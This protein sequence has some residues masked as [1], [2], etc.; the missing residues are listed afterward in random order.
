M[1]K[2]RSV[3]ATPDGTSTAVLLGSRGQHDDLASSETP[4]VLEAVELTAGYGD[5]AAIRDVSLTVRRGEIVALFGANGAGKTTTLM[6]MVG[7]L[8]R[9]GG[10]VRWRDAGTSEPLYKL[11]RRGLSFVPEEQSIISGLSVRDNLRIGRGTVKKALEFFPELEP[12]LERNAG[13][14]SGGQQQ[15]LALA[16]ALAAEPVALVID[17]LSLGLAPLV[18]ERLLEVLRLAADSQGIGVLLVEQ[19]AKR[20]LSVADRWYLLANG[21]ITA[22]GDRNSG[23]QLRTAFQTG[24]GRAQA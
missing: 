21:R 7:A 13:L 11:A 8:A 4:C 20:A 14:L 3:S 24:I 2:R 1:N 23:E 15:M 17:E 5:L 6:A 18:V 22:E 10:E 12:H 16:R 9:M 19:Q